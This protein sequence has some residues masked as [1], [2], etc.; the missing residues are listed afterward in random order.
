MD[1][2]ILKGKITQENRWHHSLPYLHPLSFVHVNVLVKLLNWTTMAFSYLSLNK[3]CLP[4]I[5][6]IAKEP[7]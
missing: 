5:F 2:F 4:S 6:F 3:I 1:N 7:L